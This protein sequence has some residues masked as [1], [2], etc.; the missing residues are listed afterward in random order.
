MIV[1]DKLFIPWVFEPEDV[2]ENTG[3]FIRPCWWGTK[4][5]GE[6]TLIAEFTVP[7]HPE[8]ITLLERVGNRFGKL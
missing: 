4:P 7:I 8:L 1:T 2:D 3:E 5:D 6:L